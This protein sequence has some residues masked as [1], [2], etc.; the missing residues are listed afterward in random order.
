MP[1]PK[2]GIIISALASARPVFVD[3]KDGITGR[4][5][6]DTDASENLP[7]PYSWV[8]L[9]DGRGAVPV[10]NIKTARNATGVGVYTAIRL[11]TRER[12]VIDVKAKDLYDQ[13]GESAANTALK[14]APVDVESWRL[15]PGRVEPADGGGLTVYIRALSHSEGEW[16]GG[17]Q[18][19]STEVG[20]LTSSKAAM[21]IVG[22]DK[23]TNL[24]DI[25]VGT[26]QSLA[27]DWSRSDVETVKA[28][29]SAGVIPL[30]ALVIKD[31]QTTITDCWTSPSRQFD[32][33]PIVDIGS[34]IGDFTDLADVPASYSGQAGKF[35]TV[36]GDESGLEFVTAAASEVGAK[37]RRVGTVIYENTLG[38]AGLFDTGTLPTGYDAYEVRLRLRTSVSSTNDTAYL[39]YN[40]DTTTTNYRNAISGSSSGSASNGVVNTPR[41]AIPP[42][43]NSPSGSFGVTTV[44]IPEPEGSKLKT[45]YAED[46]AQLDSTT[47]EVVYSHMHFWNNTAAI[48]SIQVVPD[49]A[50]T[51]TFDTGSSI[52]VIGWRE[53]PIGGLDTSSAN[54]S[55]PP[56]DAELDSAFGT[57]AAVGDGFAATIND[58]GADTAQ[59]LV[60]SNGTSWW[61]ASMTKAT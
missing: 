55:N 49:G 6:T 1:D 2:D 48:T 22:I 12:E 45:A 23:A 32:A 36:K 10:I 56:T 14:A 40:S 44:R 34:A 41:I 19:L 47:T 39:R 5:E 26:E 11:A 37:L 53:E 18:S 15:L 8:R 33:R 13:Y 21:L 43:A 29:V 30:W 46:A 4:F 3:H 9:N 16:Q 58:N 17:T 20:A 31:G 27:Y 61:Y 54:V 28:T 42:A 59:W 50:P 7:A 57:P 25:T 52:Q 38:S 35:V 60:I 24:P 51:D